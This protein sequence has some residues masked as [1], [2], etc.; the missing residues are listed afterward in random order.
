MLS[1]E[2]DAHG[3]IETVVALVFQV[4]VVTD[5]DARGVFHS[6]CTGLVTVVLVQDVVDGVAQI[7]APVVV[8]VTRADGIKW[9]QRQVFD[10][11][12]IAEAGRDIVVGVGRAR[13]AVTVVVSAQQ[14]VG[15]MVLALGTGAVLTAEVAV[16]AQGEGVARGQP[17]ADVGPPVGSDAF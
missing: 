2:I 5:G 14:V 16:E 3:A 6:L 11:V 15:I 9:R 8:C 13:Q 4:L 10:D 17:L 1:V 12:A 7:F